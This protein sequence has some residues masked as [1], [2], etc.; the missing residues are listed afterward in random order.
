M[1]EQF[2]T[3]KRKYC[4]SRDTHVLTRKPLFDLEIKRCV[5]LA[6][7]ANFVAILKIR[8]ATY[9]LKAIARV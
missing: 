4:I 1:A 2:F 8:T 7:Q 6:T 3:K 9:Q 5:I